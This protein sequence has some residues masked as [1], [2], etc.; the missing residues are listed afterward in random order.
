MTHLNPSGVDAM[1]GKIKSRELAKQETRDALIRAGI[2]VFTKEG[3]DLPSLDA[4]CARAGFTRGAFYVHFKDREA[5]FAAVVDQVLQD[6]VNWVISTGEA[7]GGLMGVVERFLSALQRGEQTFADP[8]KLLMQIVA[9]AGHK[10]HQQ[11]RPYRALID[12]AIARLADVT[13]QGQEQGLIRRDLEPAQLALLLVSSSVGFLGLIGGGLQP[14][15]AEVR[16]LV[17][18]WLFTS[19]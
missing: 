11:A 18:R 17:A 4:I 12:G 14:D 3:V 13:K 5:F 15:F 1:S 7:Q 9:R 16:A 6:F 2:A 10:D 19:G 8:H